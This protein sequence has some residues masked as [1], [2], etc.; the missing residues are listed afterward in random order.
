MAVDEDGST[1]FCGKLTQTP[2]ILNLLYKSRVWTIAQRLI[3]R[4]KVQRARGAQIALRA[5]APQ[6]ANRRARIGLEAGA[7]PPHQWHIDGMGKGKHSPFSLLVGVSLSSQTDVDCGNFCV[8]PGSHHTL[9]PL[10]KEQVMAGSSLFSKE[11][12]PAADKPQFHNGVQLRAMAGD[13]VFAHQKMAHRG[14]PNT[15]PNIR[16]QVYFRLSQVDHAEYMASGALLE[17]LWVEFDGVQAYK[18]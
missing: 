13:A 2:E 7:L 18:T 8:F 9:L 11:A 6:L 5:P 12:D 14:G 16:Y 10:L 4:G 3:G 15:S 17:D 1:K